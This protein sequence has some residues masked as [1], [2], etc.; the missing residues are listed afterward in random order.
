MTLQEK[1]VTTPAGPAGYL[2]TGDGPG[3][4]ALFI[5]GVGSAATLWEP[6]IDLVSADR[7]CIAVDLPLHGR[8]PPAASYSLGTTADFVIGFCSSLGLSGIDLVAN[9]TG[10]AVAQIVAARRPDLLRSFTLTNC[11]SHDNIP[12]KAFMPMVLLARAG[13]IAPLQRFMMRGD[14]RRARKVAF[15]TVCEDV[16]NL[17]LDMVRGWMEPLGSTRERAREFQRWLAAIRPDDVLAAEPALSRL[18]VPT[19]LVW[20]TGDKFFQIEWAYKLRDLIPGVREIVEV[21]GGKLFFPYERPAELAE[22]LRKF[23]QS[24]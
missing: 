20:G 1:T 15:G 23:W 17:P 3:S 14:L 12:P 16:T 11:D 22:P 24:L 8:T 10:G 6:V 4:A 2:D 21:P 7:R 19:L 18:E 13:L 9:D 5:H